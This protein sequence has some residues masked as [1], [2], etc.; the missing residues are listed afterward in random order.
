M[1][2]R[3]RRDSDPKQY[4]LHVT[5]IFPWVTTESFFADR[6]WISADRTA[7]SGSVCSNR[8]ANCRI[9]CYSSARGKELGPGDQFYKRYRPDSLWR[10]DAR[11][12][13]RIMSNF[14]PVFRRCA[15]Q[16]HD[17]SGR[18][19]PRSPMTLVS[20]GLGG[21][22]FTNIPGRPRILLAM[23]GETNDTRLRLA[24]KTT[25]T[26]KGSITTAG[27]NFFLLTHSL[28]K[29]MPPVSPGTR[30]NV[31]IVGKT[32]IDRIRRGT[33]RMK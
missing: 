15:F 4:S 6:R 7:P 11:S 31:Q 1:L 29:E 25:S 20:G 30:R 27:S 22:L 13:L 3:A 2:S 12:M 14:Q 21:A 19:S 9:G 8:S 33:L 24:I 5:S 18:F 16:L 10:A 28:R 32:N 26:L 23:P 17:Y